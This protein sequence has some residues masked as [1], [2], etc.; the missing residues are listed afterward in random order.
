MKKILLMALLATSTMINAAATGI[1]VS[2]TEDAAAVLARATVYKMRQ[3]AHQIILAK[4]HENLI[5][6]VKEPNLDLTTTPPSFMYNVYFADK[7]T[8]VRRYEK[9][10]FTLL[11]AVYALQDRIIDLSEEDKIF[12]STALKCAREHALYDPEFYDQ[13]LTELE[14]LIKKGAEIPTREE[15]YNKRLARYFDFIYESTRAASPDLPE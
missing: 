11:D 7:S 13:E 15:L 1:P 4:R 3:D 9:E 2:A 5:R 8:R 12:L 6:V 14:A 10:T